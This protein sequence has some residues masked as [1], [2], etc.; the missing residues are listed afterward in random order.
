MRPA[1]NVEEA[2]VEVLREHIRASAFPFGWFSQVSDSHA[3]EAQEV[4]ALDLVDEIERLRAAVPRRE[5]IE[6]IRSALIL[7]A[8]AGERRQALA[9]KPCWCAPNYD[10]ER[11]GHS[12][13][14]AA[15]REALAIIVERLDTEAP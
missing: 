9:P 6:R 12:V 14:C 4:F 5:Q 15:A 11:Y 8:P 7:L 1:P 2:A 3:A 13:A 10:E